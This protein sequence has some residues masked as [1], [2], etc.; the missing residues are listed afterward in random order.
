MFTKALMAA[1]MCALLSF[2]AFAQTPAAP[3]QP[4]GG[5]GMGAGGGMGGGM[6][7]MGPGRYMLS[8][9]SLQSLKQELSLTP[10]QEPLWKT[11]A[12]SMTSMWDM[13]NAMRQAVQGQPMSRDEHMKMRAKHMKDAQPMR[14]DLKNAR[15]ALSAALSSQQRTILDAKS[16]EMPID[17]E[18]PAPKT[19]GGK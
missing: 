19:S 6:G 5:M 16:P 1:V 18:A 9:E 8:P 7:M 10:Q 11:Y 3:V 13:R 14:E 2:P 12:D 17:F 15:T 4:M